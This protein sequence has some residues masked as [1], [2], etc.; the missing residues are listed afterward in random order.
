MSKSVESTGRARIWMVAILVAGCAA[1]AAAV[2]WFAFARRPIPRGQAGTRWIM[3]QSRLLKTQ[4]NATGIVRLKTGAEVRVGAQISGIVR[5]LFVTVGSRVTQGQVIAQIDPR[6]IEAR[7]QQARAQ[8]SQAQVTLAKAALDQNRSGQ[9]FNAGII[10][11]QQFQDASATFEIASASVQS[12]QSGVSEA[13]VDLAYVDIRAPISGTVSSVSTQQGETVA[14]SFA[15]PTFVTII[16]SDALEIVAMVDEAD[17]GNVRPGEKATFVTQTWPDLEFAG[18]L[19]RIAPVATIISGV[20]NYEVAI[21]IL[22]GITKL[23]PDMTANV[24]I[25]TAQRRLMV[26]PAGCVHRDGD[27]SFVYV[28]SPVRKTGPAARGYW[29]SHIVRSGDPARPRC[30]HRGP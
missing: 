13:S 8:L 15:T 25:T 11:Q 16:Q 24:N 21:S 23:K 30:Q 19:L 22:H 7:V 14:A 3:P 1:S 4:V 9:L 20:V 28:Q 29:Q 10:S 2:W 6:P 26:V 27:G 5:R 17:I 12:A 18:T